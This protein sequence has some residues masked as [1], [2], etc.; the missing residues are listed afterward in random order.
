M[1]RPRDRWMPLDWG[2]YL[3][4]TTHLNATEHGAYLLLIGRYWVSGCPLPD[5]DEALRKTAR[6]ETRKAWLRV[7]AIIAPLFQVAGGVW[8]HKR[9]ERD[10]AEAHR[11]HVEASEAGRRGNQKRWGKKS[12][13]D[14]VAIAGQSEPESGG[15]RKTT[16]HKLQEEKDSPP[17]PSGPADLT[18][19]IDAIARLHP[20]NDGPFGTDRALYEMRLL[21]PSLPDFT[22]ALEAWVGSEDWTKEGGKFAPSAEKWVRNGGWKTKPKAPGPRR[23]GPTIVATSG[24]GEQTATVVR[25]F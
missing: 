9:V 2:D 11:L 25:R 17:T 10:L 19:Y 7:R 13:G 6:V 3:R 21:L 18:G 23:S 12:G 16:N 8:R 1:G 5:D 24:S 22:A 14:R 20:R 15:D 4:D